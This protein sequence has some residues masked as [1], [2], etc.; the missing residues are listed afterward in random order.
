MHLIWTFSLVSVVLVSL[1]SF[2]GLFSFSIEEKKLKRWVVYL[3]GLAA[4]ALFGDVFIHLLP[5]ISRQ[6]GFTLG[7]SLSFLAGVFIFFILE[8]VIHAQ[9]YHGHDRSHSRSFVH[10]RKEVKPMAYMSLT[11]STLHNFIDGLVISSA[12]FVSIP[13]GVGTT[14]AVLFHEIPHE[15]GSFSIL[16]QGG[17]SRKKALFVNFFSALFA[18]LGAGAALVFSG[19][20]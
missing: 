4:G 19:A 6:K 5:E 1:L 8:K 12:Y 18:V 13:A 16:I 3:I 17:F 2:I 9:H 10:P 15:L 20:V 14:L 11:V 7:V